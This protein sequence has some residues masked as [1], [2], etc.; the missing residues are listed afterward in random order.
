MEADPS[1]HLFADPPPPPVRLP[2]APSRRGG[3]AHVAA[4]VASVVAP[5]PASPPDPYAGRAIDVRRPLGALLPPGMVSVLTGASHVGK[6]TFLALAVR[7]ILAGQE[8]LGHIPAADLPFIGFIGMDR[9]WETARHWFDIVGVKE[10]DRFRAYCLLDNMGFD[11]GRLRRKESHADIFTEALDILNPPEHSLVI[12]DPIALL[13]GR[14]LGDYSEVGACA[15]E[16]SR[17]TIS[18]KVTVLGTA[19]VKK[20]SA[21]PKDKF[22]RA[23]DRALGSAA[24]SSYTNTQIYVVGPEETGKSYFVI[25]YQS[26]ELPPW[27]AKYRKDDQGLFVPLTPEEA[28]AADATDEKSANDDLIFKVLAAQPAGDT[29]PTFRLIEVGEMYSIS[30]AAVFRRLKRWEVGGLIEQPTK[31]AWRL[32]T[33]EKE[34]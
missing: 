23:Q 31:G 19:H 3:G 21:D 29:I 6:T 11:W 26:H 5:A 34:S 15:G 10:C 4:C 30:R 28:N 13:L 7:E 25:G 18:R 24:I 17:I 33:K 14:N 27:S 8:V 20:M 9:R 1:P 2:T 16:L 32:A 12:V 22:L